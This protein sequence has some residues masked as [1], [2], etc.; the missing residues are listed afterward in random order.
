MVHHQGWWESI[1]IWGVISLFYMGAVITVF[2]YILHQ[3]AIKHGGPVIASTMFYILPIFGFVINFLLLG[4]L[5]T[6]G[7]IFG[8]SLAILGTYLVVRK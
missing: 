2:G 4:E 5:L 7:F 3:Y 8:C 1:T 6:P